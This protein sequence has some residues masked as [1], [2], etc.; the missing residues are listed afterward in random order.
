M[1]HARQLLVVSFQLDVKTGDEEELPVSCKEI[2]A[3]QPSG[4]FVPN[5]RQLLLNCQCIFECDWKLIVVARCFGRR[6]NLH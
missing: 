5:L 1:S 2:S 6:E 3:G 4:L